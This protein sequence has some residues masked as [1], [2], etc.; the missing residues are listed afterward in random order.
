M[1][2]TV[3][4]ALEPLTINAA[5]RTIHATVNLSAV[6]L[7]KIADACS[8]A[9]DKLSVLEHLAKKAEGNEEEQERL[10]GK[11]VDAY[12]IA[13]EPSIGA[14]AFDELVGA[15]T[16]DGELPRSSCLIPL[17]KVQ[18]SIISLID[19]R[20]ADAKAAAAFID[21]TATHEPAEG[22]GARAVTDE[23]A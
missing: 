5:G 9:G 21:P 8:K 15:L 16:H 14:A 20:R 19:A 12:R 4:S 13:M 7:A 1:E 2:I 3:T 10:A 18:A 23:E 17:T 11:M 6:S 22:E